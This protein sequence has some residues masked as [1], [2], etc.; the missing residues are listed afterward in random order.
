MSFQRRPLKRFRRFSVGGPISATLD[1]VSGDVWAAFG[2][3]RLLSSYTGS[4]VNMREDGGN[5]NQDIGYTFDN[6]IDEA[7][8]N[9]FLGGNNGFLEIWY[10]QSGNGRN[11]QQ[12]VDANQ[13]S[14]STALEKPSFDW[15]GIDQWLDDATNPTA[16]ASDWTIL[17]FVEADNAAAVQVIYSND[18]FSTAEIQHY[19]NSN[20][21]ARRAY[22][23]RTDGF[24]YADVAVATFTGPQVITH[25]L[26]SPSGGKIKLNTS[27]MKTAL[28]YTQQ[29]L[30]ANHRIGRQAGTGNYFNGRIAAVIIFNAVLSESDLI[31]IETDLINTYIDT[32]NYVEDDINGGYVVDVTGQFVTV[33]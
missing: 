22:E 9:S 17:S 32:S 31:N 8:I 5:T 2:T 3:K 33:T 27:D 28:T 23:T 24:Q 15:N 7:A 6:Q 20:I 18:D 12:T 19:F 30:T 4:L 26:D 13:P 14:Y 21:A 11:F 10:D 29:A 16:T 1:A 25:V